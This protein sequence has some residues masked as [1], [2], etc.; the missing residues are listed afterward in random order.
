MNVCLNALDELINP[1][2]NIQ[3]NSNIANKNFFILITF[4][5]LNYTSGT[6]LTNA[7][8]SFAVPG[9]TLTE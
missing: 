9:K 1:K 3:A 8:M 4:A 6:M 2:I 5:N 7:K